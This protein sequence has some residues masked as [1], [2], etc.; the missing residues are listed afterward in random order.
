MAIAHAKMTI[1]IIWA[2]T[3]MTTAGTTSQ[4][5]IKTMIAEAVAMPANFVILT[6]MTKEVKEVTVVMIGKKEIAIV[7]VARA[8][9]IMWRRSTVTLA[10]TP[11][12]RVAAAL[13]AVAAFQATAALSLIL[14]QVTARGTTIATMWRTP[15]W[16]KMKQRTS[17]LVILIQPNIIGYWR[18]QEPNPRQKE[19]KTELLDLGCFTSNA[20]LTTPRR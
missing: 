20:P 6:N 17:H 16:T 9:C 2:G 15:T 7:L 19:R 12:P 10:L 13:P 3:T 5:G 14:C 4:E 8:S 1:S 11:D 18:W